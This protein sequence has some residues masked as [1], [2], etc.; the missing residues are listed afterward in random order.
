[1][2]ITLRPNPGVHPENETRK[3]GKQ[4]LSEGVHLAHRAFFAPSLFRSLL[5]LCYS[6][7]FF[8]RF[9]ANVMIPLNFLQFLHFGAP[10]YSDLQ[11]A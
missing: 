9:P 2:V 6:L 11:S 5:F 8:R 7:L 4:C 1:M 3:Q 10:L